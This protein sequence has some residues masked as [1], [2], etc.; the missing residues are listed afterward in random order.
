MTFSFGQLCSDG[1]PTKPD[2]LWRWCSVFA[3][4]TRLISG[5]NRAFLLE[6]GI[7]VG[8]CLRA[9]VGVVVG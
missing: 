4:P 1:F 7:W 5:N 8:C 3:L 9:V 6:P 2:V